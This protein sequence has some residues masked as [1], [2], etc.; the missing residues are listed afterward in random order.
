VNLGSEGKRLTAE[1]TVRSSSDGQA[2]RHHVSEARRGGRTGG[3]PDLIAVRA[4]TPEDAQAIA[5]LL[6]ENY[7]LSYVH[8]DFYR[9]RYL[10]AALSSGRLVSTVAVHETPPIAALGSSGGCSSTR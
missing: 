1:V 7:H 6:S 4:A 9:P 3:T 10:M 2:A 8:G 5:Q